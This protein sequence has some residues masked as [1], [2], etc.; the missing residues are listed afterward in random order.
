MIAHY[1][2]LTNLWHKTAQGMLFAKEK[3]LDFVATIDTMLYDN[4][5]SCD[6]M[7]FKFDMGRDLWLTRQRFTTLQRAYVDPVEWAA[8]MNRCQEIAEKGS[9]R[10]VVTQMFAHQHPR[11]AKKYKWG[12]CMM[13]W[14]FRGGGREQ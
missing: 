11:A 5:L 14:T 6:S 13:A 1:D 3:D 8:F 10:G 4:V 7:A 9:R 12:N 2:T